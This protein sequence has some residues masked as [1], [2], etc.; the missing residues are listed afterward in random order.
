MVYDSIKAIWNI[1]TIPWHIYLS[2]SCIAISVHAVISLPELEMWMGG[3]S[4]IVASCLLINEAAF[5]YI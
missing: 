2:T 5:I 3:L 4:V 1:F